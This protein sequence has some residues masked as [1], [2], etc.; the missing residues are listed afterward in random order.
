MFVRAGKSK[1]TVEWDCSALQY[2][3]LHCIIVLYCTALYNARYCTIHKFT[4]TH[5]T[6]FRWFYMHSCNAMYVPTYTCRSC[7]DPNKC[8]RCKL[9]A[10]SNVYSIH[11]T[12]HKLP[13]KFIVVRWRIGFFLFSIQQLMQMN[14]FFLI[15]FLKHKDCL[16][17]Y[18][19]TGLLCWGLFRGLFL[20]GC[21]CVLFL[22]VTSKIGFLCDECTYKAVNRLYFCL[23]NYLAKYKKDFIQRLFQILLD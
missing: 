18:M 8:I 7:F 1:G 2:S 21:M 22:A 9:Y 4:C 23:L 13:W 3:A 12:P 15:K 17:I 11:Q 5:N 20:L 6:V 16:K 19:T 10:A 14:F